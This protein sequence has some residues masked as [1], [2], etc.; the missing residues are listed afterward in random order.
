MMHR[1]PQAFTIMICFYLAAAGRSALHAEDSSPARQRIT[2]ILEADNHEH[3]QEIRRLVRGDL[4]EGYKLEV[5][6]TFWVCGSQIQRGYV[7]TRATPLNSEGVIDG[8]VYQ[9]TPGQGQPIRI[10]IYV[11]GKRHGIEKVYSNTSRLQA[12]NPYENDK[13]HGVR[14]TYYEDGELQGETTFEHGT[15]VGEG[16]TYCPQGNVIERT[17]Y[18]DGVMHGERVQ[19]WALEGE[20]IPRRITPY[21]KGTVHGIVRECHSNGALRRTMQFRNGEPHGT[22]TS[23]DGDGNETRKRYWLR[24]EV[25]PKGMFDAE[26]EPEEDGE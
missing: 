18:Q 15:P 26:Y 23:F 3:T 25:V 22:E 21:V 1:L 20:R 11:E 13:L 6:S 2:K 24:G 8:V 16:V 9:W 5:E 14:K 7:P 4:A 10:T 19:Y 17:P 12:E